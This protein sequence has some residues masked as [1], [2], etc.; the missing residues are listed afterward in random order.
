MST[1]SALLRFIVIATSLV[2]SL[3]FGK[4]FEKRPPHSIPA[5]I[6]LQPAA[7]TL[8]GYQ[9]FS[10]TQVIPT[11]SAQTSKQGSL[12]IE[13]ASGIAA[14]PGPAATITSTH[15]TPAPQP[16]STDCGPCYLFF[17]VSQQC[18]YAQ[19]MTDLKTADCQCTL[20]ALKP[21]TLQLSIGKPNSCISYCRYVHCVQISSSST[22][23]LFTLL[24]FF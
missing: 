17:Q 5:E 9:V 15:V 14:D 1:G 11:V 12:A 13:Q 24:I 2:P 21:Y 22:I 23:R 6:N 18:T 10:F 3:T 4:K 16:G 20:L 19:L 8:S 7:S